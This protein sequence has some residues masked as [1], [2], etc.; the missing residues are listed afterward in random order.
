M[1]A[2]TPHITA[3]RQI[4]THLHRV[5]ASRDPV[6]DKLERV[7]DIVARGM[8]SEVCS[9]YLLKRGVLEL[10]AT[11]GLFP[12]AV[13]VTR[14]GMGEGLVGR[15]ARDCVYLNLEQASRHP[16]FAYRPETG[17][18]EFHSFLGVPIVRHESA[19][20]V[21]C[22]QHVKPRCYR[23]V[24]IETLQTIAMVLS[25]LIA[26]SELA[27]SADM[28]VPEARQHGMMRLTG[29][30][31]VQGLARGYV[32]FHEPRV[33]ID[34]VLATDK[35]HEHECARQA[36]AQLKDQTEGMM[37]RVE[38]TSPGDHHD[39]LETYRMFAHDE[40]W[41]R[42]IAQ[43]ID[44]GLTAP[45][46]VEH[47]YL[48]MRERMGSGAPSSYV[49]ERIEDLEDISNRLIRIMTGRA[50]TAAQAGLTRDSLLLARRIGPAELLEYNQSRL[51]GLVLEEGSLTAHVTIVARAMN[52][53]ILGRVRDLRRR[54][55]EGEQAII[56]ATAVTGALL[57]RP[58]ST[59]QRKYRSLMA[60][61]RERIAQYAQER[62]L[63]VIT[64]DGVRVH[65]MMNAGLASDM[66]KLDETN[67]D[68]VGLFRTEFPFL[69]SETLPRRER[70]T[71]LYRQ[72]LDAAKDRPVIFR[73]LDI[74]GDK[75]VPY[76]RQED[77]LVEENPA[78]G[79]RA[80]RIALQ[81]E[82]LLKAQAR[83]L[84][85]AASGRVLRI[86]FP[87][88][89]E[90]WEFMA[91]RDLVES[92]KDWLAAR[93]SPLP[94]VVKYG[95]MLEVPALAE[96]LDA[97]L[98]HA[99]FLSI[100]TN[101]LIQFMFAADRANPRLAMRYDWLSHTVLRFIARILNAG[102]QYRTKISVC[103]EMGGHPLEALALIAL[104]CDRLSIT[105]SAIGPVKAVLRAAR[106]TPLRLAMRAWLNDPHI[107]VRDAL[108]HKAKEQ[109][110]P[111]D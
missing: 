70:Q 93:G 100:G 73:T 22:L 81:R 23:P 43:A 9:I 68:G 47:V 94:I 6:Q 106:I 24:E 80:L 111:I 99:D 60:Q 31:L 40:G 110:L 83:A 56:D 105:P 53:P 61:R 44:T 92:Q 20:G 95:C 67:A 33:A 17:E 86:M 50:R 18:K 13:H 26:A 91:A 101:D 62:H 12:E 88:V 87:M 107:S 104:G 10:S 90:P 59:T 75:K 41:A 109:G 45:A 36:F 30:S 29:L 66:A 108:M 64:R 16:D 65:L 96:Q 63:P 34:R 103:G 28:L 84:L 71:A 55:F 38:F 27:Q 85:D 4:L 52:I 89:A 58:T 57:V 35:A 11:Y 98:P 74:G 25:E 46:A 42:R 78:M 49:Q 39:I 32:T 72:V 82:G 15:I 5:M 69:V 8:A 51:K 7:V 79:W 19:I 14:L 102:A 54:I 1:M 37:R 77:G 3:S 21:L 76:M 48:R 2:D 97:L